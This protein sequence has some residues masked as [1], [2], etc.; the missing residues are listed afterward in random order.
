MKREVK[1][2][3]VEAIKDDRQ[4]YTS[5]SSHSTKFGIA[6][7]IYTQ[8]TSGE[9]DRKI[10]D[11]KW[12]KIA[13]LLDVDIANNAI[14]KPAQTEVFLYITKQLEACQ[15]QSMAAILCDV[16]DLGKT[17]TARHYKRTHRNVVYI[18]C[19]MYK[20]RSLFI[21]ELA[22]LWGCDGRG[23]LVTIEQDLVY[24]LRSIER[25]LIILD[26]AGDL[27]YEAF[28]EIKALW[29]ATERHCGW[30]MM[31]ADGLKAKIEKSIASQRVGYTEIFSRFGNKFSKVAPLS[32]ADQRKFLIG[33]AA[34]IA[35]EN[36]PEGTK[37]DMKALLTKA[38]GS[39][40]KLYVEIQKL[41]TD[42]ASVQ[43]SN[44]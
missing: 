44:G 2:R 31:G 18:D 36:L 38:D 25:P 37:V 34:I 7:A 14:W 21:R 17:Y 11:A 30:Y 5:N 35:K 32:K 43:V 10:T 1:L 41:S 6:P 39:L 22:R 26:E 12:A 27:S 3:I 8:I 9:V 24:Y 16:A 42:T 23:S 29:N 15:A 33:Q 4:N 13:R 19:S 40:R 28:L 20:S